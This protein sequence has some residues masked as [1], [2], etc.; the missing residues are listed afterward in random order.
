MFL[1][2]LIC[3]FQ[4]L[5]DYSVCG[6]RVDLNMRRSGGKVHVEDLS[7]DGL[8]LSIDHLAL[9]HTASWNWSRKTEVPPH[10]IEPVMRATNTY[11]SMPIRMIIRNHVCLVTIV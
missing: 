7:S 4:L 10:T 2:F 9:P 5:M 6:H 1:A 3:D 8:P 11:P